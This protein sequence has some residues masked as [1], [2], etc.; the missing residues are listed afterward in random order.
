M[1][2]LSKDFC[3]RIERPD[4]AKAGFTFIPQEA[5]RMIG[6]PDPEEDE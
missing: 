1:W 2:V 6:L 3:E 4:I 5:A